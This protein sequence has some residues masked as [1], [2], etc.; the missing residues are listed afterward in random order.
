M[1]G[2]AL[3]L[4]FPDQSVDA[5]TGFMLLPV[6]DAPADLIG[7]VIRVLRPGGRA[8]LMVPAE[9]LNPVAA[10]RLAEAQGFSSRDQD[11]LVAWSLA[12]RRFSEASLAALAG[13]HPQANLEILPLLDGLALG[14]LLSISAAGP[15]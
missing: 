11:T 7:E 8:C 2:D 10:L 13:P 5:I 1:R 9:A 14:A 6:L 12:G 15:A 4:P 3:R